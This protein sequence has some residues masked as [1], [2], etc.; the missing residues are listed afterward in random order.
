MPRKR[1][2]PQQIPH[3]L[4]ELEHFPAPVIDRAALEKLLVVRRREAIRLMH[5]FG[6]F[7]VGKT[8]L[9][10]RQQLIRQLEKVRNTPDF[11]P[12]QR[13]RERLT[14]ILEKI[15]RYQT[16]ARIRIPVKPEA[17]NLAGLPEGV[18]LGA[19]RLTVEFMNAEELL[20]KLFVLARAAAD[21]FERFRAA[22]ESG[23]SDRES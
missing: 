20:A 9:I 8:F 11:T 15:R 14:E 16:A 22:V 10:E 19:G 4:E 1:E 21:D 13:R 3:A 12:E 18:R 7:Q 6:G 17:P 5:R 23:E 2:W